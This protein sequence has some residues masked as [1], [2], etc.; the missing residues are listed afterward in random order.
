VSAA[1][2]AG[3]MLV[4]IGGECRAG[5]TL[6]RQRALWGLLESAV[7]SPLDGVVESFSTATGHAI[8]RAAPRVNE[9]VAHIPG[10]VVEVL[11]DEGVVIET[12]AAVV[13]GAFGVD[14]ET[15]GLL[16]VL[17]RE[18]GMICTP[19]DVKP[20]HRGCVLVVGALITLEVIRRAVAVGAAAL[21]AGGMHDADLAAWL[22]REIGSGVTGGESAGLTA[23]VTEGFGVLP[24]AD[25]TFALLHEHQG[26]PACVDGTTQI[27]AGVQRPEIV[28]PLGPDVETGREPP[29]PQERESDK[30]STEL[31]IGSS[32]RMIRDP[33]FGMLGTVV[34]LPAAPD[35]LPSEVETRVVVVRLAD[36]RNVRVPRANVELISSA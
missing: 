15:R 34:D 31:T 28:I 36:G 4:P 13:Q 23:I 35:R 21:I 7:V 1:E 11:L 32:L 17:A 20:D 18:P 14:G 27:R 6:A 9:V 25:R 33:H 3:A 29:A 16:L 2:A 30:P 8:V 19:E 22:G 5:Q 12:H 26:R 10:I 24:M